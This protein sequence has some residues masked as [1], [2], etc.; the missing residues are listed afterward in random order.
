MFLWFG[1]SVLGA[2][3]ESFR[4][5]HS[6]R[7]SDYSCTLLTPGEPRPSILLLVI[8][9]RILAEPSP[10][11]IADHAHRLLARELFLSGQF[12]HHLARIQ[13]VSRTV[14]LRSAGSQHK[15]VGVH[16]FAAVIYVVTFIDRRIAHLK[17]IVF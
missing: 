6:A 12:L 17:S 1:H 14:S 4:F 7:L 11:M 15:S 3:S 9:V 13:H 8:G 10:S 16:A 2:D 5:S